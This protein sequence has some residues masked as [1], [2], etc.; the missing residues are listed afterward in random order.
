[1]ELGIFLAAFVPSYEIA[2]DPDAEHTMIMNSLELAQAAD[3]AGIKY[4][5]QSEHTCSRS[6]HTCRRRKFSSVTSRPPR[7]GTF[8]FSCLIRS[9]R[10]TIRLEPPRRSRC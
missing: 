2:R 3:E 8:G 6:T 10:L 4:I 7:K 5:W 1:M 9:L